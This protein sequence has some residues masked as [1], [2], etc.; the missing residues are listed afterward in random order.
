MQTAKETHK[1]SPRN[2]HTGSLKRRQFLKKMVVGSCTGDLAWARYDALSKGNDKLYD[3]SRKLRS[4][5]RSVAVRIRVNGRLQAAST[6]EPQQ[7][8]L[9]VD[10]QLQYVEQLRA[11]RDNQAIAVRH[12]RQALARIDVA[13][14]QTNSQLAAE[15]RRIICR[16]TSRQDELFSPGGPL[17][18]AEL[19]LI[20]IPGNSAQWWML[21]PERPVHVGDAWLLDSNAVASLLRLEAISKSAVRCTLEKAVKSTLTIAIQGTAEGAVGGAATLVRVDGHCQLDSPS[22]HIRQLDLRVW[23]DRQMGHAQ[24]GFEIQAQIEAFAEPLAPVPS[25][26]AVI[27]PDTDKNSWN[28]RLL[29]L[30]F[31]ASDGGFRLL[32]DRRWRVLADTPEVSILRYIERGKLVA[33]ANISRLVDRGAQPPWTKATLQDKIRQSLGDNFTRFL[34]SSQRQDERGYRVLRVRAAGSAEDVK[35]IWSY[36]YLVDRAGRQVSL[37]FTHEP[38]H[39]ALFAAADRALADSLRILKRPGGSA[40]QADNNAVERFPQR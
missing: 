26:D 19:D 38:K 35:L 34:E 14:Q 33:Q 5:R 30:E 8:P 9:H 10:G 2:R 15:H 39:T 20:D 1:G 6:G 22:Q 36:W 28:D 25:G 37:I 12:Y 3:I 4:A 29:L 31:Q 40:R 23:E 24:P 17:T 7:L 11:G 18:R 32:H 13:G 21:L 27:P 16:T